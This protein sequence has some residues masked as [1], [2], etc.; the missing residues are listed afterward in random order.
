M[1]ATTIV[2]PT[3]R[4]DESCR[5]SST[6]ETIPQ[7]IQDYKATRERTMMLVAPLEIEDYVVQTA[8][9]MSPPRWH[10]GHTTW[11]FEMVLKD[12]APTYK[13]YDEKFLFIFNSYYEQYGKRIDKASRG[14]IS[15][16]TVRATIAY[17]HA[18][19][20]QLI[21]LL[22]HSESSANRDELVRLV[23]LGI[24]HEMQHE[25][26]LVYD[27][28]HLLADLYNPVHRHELPSGRKLEG[29]VE[30][31]GGLFDLGYAGDG[32]A[33]DNEKP[34]H[35]VYMVDYSIDRSPVTNSDYLAF[36]E[37]GG[38]QDYR[39]WLSEG[40]AAV[41]REG[42]QAPLYWETDDGN[43]WL[44][45]GFNGV[46]PVSE[47]ANSPVCHV[48]FFEASAYARWAGKRLPTEAEWEKAACLDPATGQ[49]K[50]FPWGEAP[51]T[52]ERANFLESY[53]WETAPAGSLEQGR[54]PY[55]CDQMLGDVWQWTIS[56]YSPYPGFKTDFDEYNDKW[57]I[58]Q[59]VL[60]GGS[61]ATPA[62]HIRT[63]YRNFFHPEERWMTSGFRC[64]GT[65]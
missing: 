5:T 20:E 9:Y 28:K 21:E 65:L 56:D 57:F 14:T 58:G 4:P 22:Q 6:A 64:A 33:F 44:I 43:G 26:L 36:I 17:R 59:R 16:P 15:R 54:S 51:V 3:Q 45:H 60:R 52:P 8:P 27:V 53:L 30:I 18:I 29:M 39:W 42:W 49:K 31:A 55:G 13:L 46:N 23:R 2:E 1:S 61:Y 34:Q 41:Q 24:E 7:I 50:S 19:D 62:P 12:H 37:D 38:Y 10:L 32:F 35:P 11:F 47:R 63:T 40:W 25:E 48:S